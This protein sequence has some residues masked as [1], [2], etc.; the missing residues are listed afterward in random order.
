MTPRL[1]NRLLDE[2]KAPRVPQYDRA[3]VRRG[4][5][6]IGVGGFHRAHQAAYT[7]AVLNSGDMR[8]GTTG[9][10]LRASATSQ[11]LLSQDCLY[12]A[13]SVHTVLTVRI[14]NISLM[15]RVWNLW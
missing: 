7:E 15:R 5:V 2:L 9:V 6:H 1:G 8:W 10:S 4:M 11:A 3:A 12:T 14:S 13:R